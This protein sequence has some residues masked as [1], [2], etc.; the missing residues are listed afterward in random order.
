MSSRLIQYGFTA[1][2][3]GRSLWSQTILQKYG[4]GL[5]DCK[6]Y[7]IDY[8]GTLI[9]RGGLVAACITDLDEDDAYRF[10]PFIFAEEDANTFQLLF[11]DSKIR[12]LQQGRYQLESAKDVTAVTDGS[13]Y[14]QFACEA[15]DYSVGDL[16]EFYGDD[17]PAHLLGQT[18]VISAVPDVDNFRCTPINLATSLDS[19]ADASTA[20]VS[21]YRVYTLASPYGASDLASLYFSQ[22]RDQIKITSRSFVPRILE[23]QADGTWTL[24]EDD[25][26]IAQPAPENLDRKARSATG[27]AGAIF[28][29]T[30]INELGEESLPTYYLETG[31]VNY[32]AT[33]GWISLEWDATVDAIEYNIYRSMVYSNDAELSFAA[34]LGYIGKAWAPQFTDDNIIP[35]FTATPPKVQN[36]FANSAIKRID[37]TAAGSGYARTD[38]IEI[39]DTGS[40]TGAQATLVVNDSGEVI[41]VLI[42]SGGEN[43]SNP[44]ASITTSGGSGATF[45]IEV[46]TDSGNDPAVS[47]LYGQRQVYASS[48][49][50]PMVFWGSQIGLFS[51]FTYSSIVAADESYL[52]EFNSLVVGDIKHL[53]ETGAGLL[54]F[55]NVGVWLAAGSDGGAITPTDVQA[56]PQTAVGCSDLPPLKVDADV[57]YGE[58]NNRSVRLLQYNDYSSRYGGLNVSVLA[59]ELFEAPYTFTSWCYEARPYSLVWMARNDGQIVCGTIVAEQQVYAWGKHD[60]AGVIESALTVPESDREVT[61]VIIARYLSGRWVRTIEYFADR[62]VSLNEDHVGVDLAVPFGGSQPDAKLTFSANTANETA[63]ATASSAVFSLSDEGK[64]IKWKNG[65]AYIDTYNS[66]TEVEVTIINEFDIAVPYITT[67]KNIPAGEWYLVELVESYRLPL[68]FRPSTVS[69]IGDGKVHTEQTVASDGTVTFEEDMGYGYIGLPFRCRAQCL[70]LSADGTIIEDSRKVI[71]GAGVRYK[72][73]RGLEVG[74]DDDYMYRLDDEGHNLIVEPDKL[75]SGRQYTAISD[76]WDGRHTTDYCQ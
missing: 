26:D 50:Y 19:W 53:L 47:A 10:V 22:A 52:Y 16:V 14:T 20:A 64:Y 54:A 70:P 63:T 25:F 44:S 24:I 74:T 30:A 59:R 60:T 69:V 11:T 38:T 17:V 33:A 35:D 41:G 67:L 71:I 29:V 73:S 12:F 57:L 40:G 66:S 55:T 58:V 51:N 43:Y 46:G 61:Y 13:T 2:Y 27:G 42:D 7:I 5:A 65:K 3:V 39:S 37:V 31:I 68:N 1:G 32:T 45:D 23:R 49:N 6:N 56:D 34:Q 4:Y 8:S 76:E 48:A 75:Q 9:S 28:A 21:A 15:H 36:P 72:D 18:V 62:A